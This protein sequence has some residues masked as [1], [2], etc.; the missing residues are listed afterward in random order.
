MSKYEVVKETGGIFYEIYKDGE[1]LV[2]GGGAFLFKWSAVRQA[3]KL[4]RG[5]Y[6]PLKVVWSSG[7]SGIEAAE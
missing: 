5:S 2:D 4:A 3:K 7:E 6:K 1:Y